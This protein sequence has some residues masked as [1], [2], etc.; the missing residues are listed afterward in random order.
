MRDTVKKIIINC[1]KDLSEIA[2]DLK[3]VCNAEELE[4]SKGNFSVQIK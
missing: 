2:E 1:E 4:I 3:N